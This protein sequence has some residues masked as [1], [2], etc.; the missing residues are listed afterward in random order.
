MEN[1]VNVNGQNVHQIGQNPVSRLLRIPEKP[2]I[3][4]WIISTLLLIVILFVGVSWF[5]LNSKNIISPKKRPVSVQTDQIVVTGVIRT[6]GLSDEEKQKFGLTAVDYQITD[7]RDYSKA[8]QAGQIMGYFLLSNNITITDELLGKCVSVEG[9]IPEE[10]KNKNK[11]DIYNR[12]VLNIVI[13]ERTDSSNCNPYSQVQLST[14]GTQ[15]KLILRGIIVHAKRP[16]PDIGYDYQL[17][18]TEPFVDKFSSYGSPQKVSL[19]EVSPTTN[20]LWTELE[21]NIDKEITVE[22]YM[23]WGYAESR[24]LQIIS[25]KGTGNSEEADVKNLIAK[26]EKYIQDRDV[27]GLMSLYT[28]AKTKDEIASYRNLMGKDPDVGAPR[29]FNN[30]TSNFIVKNWKIA[31]REYPDNKE[32]IT[33][34]DNKYFVVVEETRKSWCNAVPC[35]GSYSFEDTSLYIFEIVNLNSQWTVDRYYFMNQNNSSNGGPKYEGLNF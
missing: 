13:L 20:S 3:N 4:Y 5:V 23:A 25:V 14:D 28:P 17:K 30:V 19:V 7:F 24:Y 33:K 2:K 34:V 15:E 35:A 6:S 16:V 8:Y 31:R 26:F 12:I 18:L 9:T 1:Q 27:Q 22:G 29:L 21:D 10:W 32:L 11:A